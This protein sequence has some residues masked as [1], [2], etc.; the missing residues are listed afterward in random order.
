[1]F[2]TVTTLVATI[3][4]ALAASSAVAAVPE[5]SD[6]FPGL[7]ED[8]MRTRLDE[9]DLQPLEGIWYYPNERTTLGIERQP[10]ADRDLGYRII[11]LDGDDINLLP[12]TVVGYIE[13]T[14]IDNKYRLW[15]YCERDRLTLLHPLECVATLGNSETSLTFEPPHWTVKVRINFARFLPTL[16]RGISVIPTAVKEKVPIGFRKIYPANGNGERFNQIRYL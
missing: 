9:T 11:L 6:F 16:F 1:M 4:L 8:S 10:G 14:A 13:G 7:D 5:H 3:A 15:L 12:G 2:R